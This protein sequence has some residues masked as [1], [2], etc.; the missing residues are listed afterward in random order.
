M[1]YCFVDDNL[2]KV[3]VQ[4]GDS[5]L[6]SPDAK[7]QLQLYGDKGI[8]EKVHLAQSETNPKN[9]FEQN[10]KDTF[11]INTPDIGQVTPFYEEFR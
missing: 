8:S 9:P 3:S 10:K 7:V 11:T 5:K 4:T 1:Y 2:Y 6:T